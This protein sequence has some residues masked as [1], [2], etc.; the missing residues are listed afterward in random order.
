MLQPPEIR[1][2]VLECS[3]N[4]EVIELSSPAEHI[5]YADHEM[6]LPNAE[7][8][9]ERGFNGQKFVR[10][11]A[12][13]AVWKP[14]RADRFEC[15][16]TGIGRATKGL[17]NANVI[18]PVSETSTSPLVQSDG[19]SFIFV[20]AGGLKL[21]VGEDVSELHSGDSFVIPEGKEYLFSDCSENLE[22]LRVAMVC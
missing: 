22:I 3:E 19:F 1:H 4:L 18:R 20:I 7:I 16:D 12:S 5:T 2:R 14:W 17:G 15:R 13:E 21:K 10:H 8:N 6:P 9:T 11:I